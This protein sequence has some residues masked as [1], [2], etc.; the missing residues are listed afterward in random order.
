[1]GIPPFFFFLL[2]P[3]F[4][5]IVFQTFARNDPPGQAPPTRGRS[6]F[7]KGRKKK[8]NA[9]PASWE[10]PSGSPPVR[11]PVGSI[12]EERHPKNT[13]WVFNKVCNKRQRRLQ[14]PES[15][16]ISSNMFFSKWFRFFCTNDISSPHCMTTYYYFFKEK[17]NMR[18]CFSTRVGI[19]IEKIKYERNTIQKITTKKL[20]KRRK[21]T[22]KSW[23]TTS[24]LQKSP[25]VVDQK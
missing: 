3:F 1:M 5:K 14:L 16:S 9:R 12:L 6:V 25:N 4:W 10:L 20:C 7:K 19:P 24:A 17:G 2:F 13:N 21:R 23:W 18:K 8:W 11:F 22:Q 15:T